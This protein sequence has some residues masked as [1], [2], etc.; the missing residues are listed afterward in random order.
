MFHRHCNWQADRPYW[1]GG[2]FP[3]TS[4]SCSTIFQNKTTDLNEKSTGWNQTVKSAEKWLN[5][6]IGS[7]KYVV[8]PWNMVWY[9]SGS[10]LSIISPVADQ[11]RGSEML[12][13]CQIP[14]RLYDL[15][16]GARQHNV[17]PAFELPTLNIKP[18]EN[19]TDAAEPWLKLSYI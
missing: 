18:G 10:S 16:P 9:H 2:H 4:H 1:H 3:L 8:F 17:I 19:I 5:A 12:T 7:I 14:L 15:Q 6:S 13:I 11:S